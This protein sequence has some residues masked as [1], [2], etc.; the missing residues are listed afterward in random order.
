[1]LMNNPTFVSPEKLYDAQSDLIRGA[2]AG[3]DICNVMEGV[4]GKIDDLVYAK[5]RAL[6]WTGGKPPALNSF[7]KTAKGV[8]IVS[9]FTGCGG[10]DLGF[11]ALGFDHKAAFEFNEIFCKT[12][13]VN[14]PKWKVFGPPHYNGDVSKTDEIIEQLT[15][16]IDTPFEGVFV[17][18]PPCQPFSI[19]ANQRFSRS[20]ENFKRVGFSHEKNGNLL[21]DFVK[22]IVHFRPA[23]FVIENV[24]GLRDLDG[25]EQL[26][27]AIKILTH[28]GYN[29]EEPEVWNAADYGVPQFRQ[30]MFVVGARVQGCFEMPLKRDHVGCGAVLDIL[31]GDDALNHETRRHGVGSVE[32]YRVLDYGKRDKLGRVDRLTPTRPSKT[33][34]AGGTNGGGRSHLHPEIP[35]TLSVRECA[36]LQTFPDDY[37]FVGPTARQFTQVG[38]AVPVVLA[39]TL[40]AQI[41][42]AYF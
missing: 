9:F 34:I 38:N 35:R 31:P 29:V 20:G 5:S 42:K 24:P 37:R 32:R 25:G 18:G 17:G 7:K 2:D 41:S 4:G 26:G 8:P 15:P 36:R 16:I 13:R 30:R 21:F 11:E 3:V 28:A 6:A 14:R 33:V 10:M 39:A 23:S 12:L 27:E 1:M 40:A 19:A 22:L